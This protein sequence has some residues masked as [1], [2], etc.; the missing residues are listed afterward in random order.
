MRLPQFLIKT[1]VHFKRASPPVE[2]RLPNGTISL[3]ALTSKL[4][5]LFPDTDNKMVRMVDFRE[6]LVDIDGRVK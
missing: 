3:A 5:E 1:E 4:N 6:D 2:F